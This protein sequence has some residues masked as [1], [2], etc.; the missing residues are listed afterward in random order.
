MYFYTVYHRLATVNWSVILSV[1]KNIVNL[2][3]Q[4]PVDIY[5]CLWQIYHE[6]RKLHKHY[7]TKGIPFVNLFQQ[8]EYICLTKENCQVYD[9]YTA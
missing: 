9:R 8:W 3:K 5:P 6:G 1:A 4:L 2:T 7:S